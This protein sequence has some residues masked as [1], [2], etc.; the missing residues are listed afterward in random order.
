MLEP[1]RHC[2]RFLARNGRIPLPS[3]LGNLVEVR[4][5]KSAPQNFRLIAA[6]RS[7]RQP[8]QPDGAAKARFPDCSSAIVVLDLELMPKRAAAVGNKRVH[9]NGLVAPKTPPAPALP[10]PKKKRAKL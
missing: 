6:A 9:G 8:Q 2:R 4:A 10:K 1:D 3:R 7:Q 5:G